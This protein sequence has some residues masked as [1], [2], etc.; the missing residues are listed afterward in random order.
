MPQD[1]QQLGAPAPVPAM[2]ARRVLRPVA[3]QAR[4]G[5]FP[6]PGPPHR[7]VL[8]EGRGLDLVLRRRGLPGAQLTGV[9]TAST[10]TRCDAAPEGP[11]RRAVTTTRC[12]AAL[13]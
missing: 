13:R 8:R 4:I 12:D 1:R 6:R 2:R 3:E 10:T 11:L 5:P 9:S 7:P